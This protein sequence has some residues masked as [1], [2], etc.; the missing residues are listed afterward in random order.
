MSIVRF[1]A[2]HFRSP[3]YRYT[4]LKQYLKNISNHVLSRID[5]FF[6]SNNPSRTEMS[7]F[8]ENLQNLFLKASQ[9]MK[10]MEF[11][12]EISESTKKIEFLQQ[13]NE[14][15]M[16]SADRL[17]YIFEEIKMT[18]SYMFDVKYAIKSIFQPENLLPKVIYDFSSFTSQDFKK[19]LLE[20]KKSGQNNFYKQNQPEKKF[21]YLKFKNGFIDSTDK[22]NIPINSELCI[23]EMERI[24]LN[25]K[26]FEDKEFYKEEAEQINF[27]K[28]SCEISFV[29]SNKNNFKSIE[30]L[31]K[32][33]LKKEDISSFDSYFIKDGILFLKGNYLTYKMA[34]CGEINNCEWKL[35]DIE[36]HLRDKRITNL[37][38]NNINGIELKFEE[39]NKKKKSFNSLIL[40]NK[41]VDANY[42]ARNSYEC[43]KEYVK[44]TFNDFFVSSFDFYL[45]CFIKDIIFY[46]EIEI[47][48]KK[49]RIESDAISFFE[50]TVKSEIKNTIEKV[51][52]NILR[53]NKDSFTTFQDFN[54]NLNEITEYYCQ[55]IYKSDFTSLNELYLH[56]YKTTIERHFYEFFIHLSELK[57]LEIQ[58]NYSDK[59]FGDKNIFLK[60]DEN[61]CCF[62]IES[63]EEEIY[64]KIFCGHKK[65]ETDLLFVTLGPE[66][67]NYENNFR[68]KTNSESKISFKNISVLLEKNTDLFLMIYTLYLQFN[69]EIFLENEILFTIENTINVKIANFIQINSLY[70]NSTKIQIIKNFLDYKK[71]CNKIIIYSMNKKGINYLEEI[72]Q[73][74][75][76]K[77]LGEILIYR[78]IIDSLITVNNGYF[79]F[80]ITFEN[81]K[82]NFY[83]EN[84]IINKCVSCKMEHDVST[85]LEYL[86][87]F[88]LF[89]ILKIPIKNIYCN[90]I[91][92]KFNNFIKD[93]ILMKN[94][95]K[96]EYF[97][98]LNLNETHF[99]LN[100]ENLKSSVLL[101][102][103]KVSSNFFNFLPTYSKNFLLINDNSKF[104]FILN[105]KE[106]ILKDKIVR[107]GVFFRNYKNIIFD[108][109]FL[110]CIMEDLLWEIVLIKIN[111]N[112]AMSNHKLL[113][114]ENS[115]IYDYLISTAFANENAKIEN[116]VY[117]RF[118][119]CKGIFNELETYE[120]EC[121]FTHILNYDINYLNYLHILVDLEQIKNFLFRILLRKE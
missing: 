21:N 91:T 2:H 34:L 104:N 86:D 5:D 44:G 73:N 56:I 37:I 7:D 63:I 116:V 24:D 64:I 99:N 88:S 59:Q 17:A 90:Y 18:S 8:F 58:K 48:G 23:N 92:I 103:T 75:K 76:P 31:I 45:H 10:V 114:D 3:N 22:Q 1:K 111:K 9:L 60:K 55:N 47:N 95:N 82:I 117:I 28:D 102:K 54:T 32:I 16:I 101:R 100:P 66:N 33:Y 14:R 67:I 26:N 13:S 12:R 49:K 109:W 19:R 36:T 70:I 107:M 6:D 29:D 94:E 41:I 65:K 78:Y 105:L 106:Q 81:G 11:K 20:Y 62:K 83:S 40:F 61:F 98:I 25:K 112:I 35:L 84:E 42:E 110:K 38:V 43:I 71:L 120:L 69:V 85:L 96:L 80:T 97:D 30:L 50:N 119:F 15:F 53:R 87:A 46:K 52:E 72:D 4:S 115:N 121:F 68:L 108:K 57:N 77:K 39:E 118:N 79:V 74:I 27:N 93:S 113:M 89:F 51:Q